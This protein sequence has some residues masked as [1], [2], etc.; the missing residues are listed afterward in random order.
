MAIAASASHAGSA[1][2]P[3]AVKKY[4]LTSQWKTDPAGWLESANNDVKS[5]EASVK[6]SEL[7]VDATTHI[8]VVFYD[9]VCCVS[10]CF[11]A[12]P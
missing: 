12:L 7:F 11:F 9:L 4:G 5:R 1:E 3:Q 8:P 10:R 2:P 6:K